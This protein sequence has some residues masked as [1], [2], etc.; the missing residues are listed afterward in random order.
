ME[1]LNG[2]VIHEVPYEKEV[3]EGVAPAVTVV[4]PVCHTIH[5]IRETAESVLKQD[6]DAWEMLIVCGQGISDDNALLAKRYA[7]ADKRIRVIED[8]QLSGIARSLNAGIGHARGKYVALIA[9]G[10]V[11]DARR[12]S[13]QFAYMEEKQGVGVTQFYQRVFGG[14]EDDFIYRP[15]KSAEAMKTKLVFFCDVCFSTVMIRKSAMEGQRIL[16]DPDARFPEYDF[17]VRMVQVTDFETIPKIYGASR[18][19]SDPFP[20]HDDEAAQEEMCEITAKLISEKLKVQIPPEKWRLLGGRKNVFSDMVKGQKGQALCDLQDI[21]FEI[22]KEN[23][24][25]RPFSSPDLVTAISAKWRWSRYNEPWQGETKV[26]GIGQAL[27]LS[28]SEDEEKTLSRYLMRKLS[29]IVQEYRYRRDI[30]ETEHLVDML[31]N[32]P[33]EREP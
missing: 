29:P 24:I 4:L 8:A 22:W 19:G 30:E 12:L 18:V 9:A 11:S 6:F 25:I 28:G 31:R 1:V 7:E 21:L 32:A 5:S 2:L 15:P 26:A 14:G 16:F 10:D 23:L 3:Q 33:E 13:A 20:V 27:E 17:W